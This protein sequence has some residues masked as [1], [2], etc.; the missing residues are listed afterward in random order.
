MDSAGGIRSSVSCNGGHHPANEPRT[1]IALGGIIS[2]INLN[3]PS[4]FR[5]DLSNPLGIS[6]LHHS[7]NGSQ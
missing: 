4:N 7:V 3:R 1:K 6:L 5:P 2:I